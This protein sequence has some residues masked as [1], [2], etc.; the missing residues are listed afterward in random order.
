MPRVTIDAFGY[1]ELEPRTMLSTSTKLVN[2]VQ[3][4]CEIVAD[5]ES[6]QELETIAAHVGDVVTKARTRILNITKTDQRIMAKETGVVPKPLE[7]EYDHEGTWSAASTMG[8]DGV[9][10]IWRIGACEDGTFDVN[11]TDSELCATRNKVKTFLGLA[12]AKSHCQEREDEMVA[13]SVAGLLRA[14]DDS[15]VSFD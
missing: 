14:D 2:H 4:L 6:E 7:W 8:H 3:A 1:Y 15:D 11:E 13:D 10:F 9:C 12:A 5:A